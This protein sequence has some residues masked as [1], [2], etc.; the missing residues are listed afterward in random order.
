VRV[1]VNAQ[2]CAL[3]RRHSVDSARA[4]HPGHSIGRPRQAGLLAC[5]SVLASPSRTLGPVVFDAR[6]TAHS[7]GGSPGFNPSSRLIPV[8]NLSC[9][10]KVPDSF[11]RVNRHGPKRGRQHQA[12]ASQ[13]G[14]VSTLKL[15]LT[16]SP[17]ATREPRHRAACAGLPCERRTG[18]D[19]FRAILEAGARHRSSSRS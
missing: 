7:C 8:G 16:L 14:R 1:R 13:R 18:M 17:T 4:A 2:P 12:H 6:R 9:S 10:R 5:G 11:G 3:S 15:G 19:G